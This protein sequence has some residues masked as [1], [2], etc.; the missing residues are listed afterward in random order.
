MY[1]KAKYLTKVSRTA[2]A[3]ILF[4][5]S[6]G[7]TL[8]HH[9]CVMEGMK[10]CQ[11]MAMGGTMDAERQGHNSW[12]AQ[13]S[14]LCC[15][16]SISGGLTGFTAIPEMLTKVDI[17]KCVLTQLAADFSNKITHQ[18]TKLPHF[19]QSTQTTSP[20]PVEKYILYASLLI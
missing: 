16:N 9:S 10:C 18:D 2:I 5:V 12:I 8:A 13:G 14:A 1:F 3:L 19:I 4:A 7:F 20:P 6:S 11:T 17:Q 15:V